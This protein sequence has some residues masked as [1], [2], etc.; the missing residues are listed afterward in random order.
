MATT[1]EVAIAAAEEA[2]FRADLC[3]TRKTRSSS[4]LSTTSKKPTRNSLKFCSHSRYV[5]S[6]QTV[7]VDLLLFCFFHFLENQLGRWREK[8]E[9]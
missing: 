3:P 1:I 7:D 8:R 2:L 5:L 4:I 9:R 6:V